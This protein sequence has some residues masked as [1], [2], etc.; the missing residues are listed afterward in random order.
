MPVVCR[1]IGCESKIP[2]L[3]ALPKHL[4]EKVPSSRKG[5]ALAEYIVAR[6]SVSQPVAKTTTII[7]RKM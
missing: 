5:T 6:E 3:L 4:P 1:G 7:S 2:L